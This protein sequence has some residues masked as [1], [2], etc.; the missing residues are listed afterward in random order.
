MSDLGG[1]SMHELFRAEA[2]THCAALSDGLLQLERTPGDLSVITA[3]MRA[4][5]SI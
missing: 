1:F 2:E 5:H 4:A 3:L